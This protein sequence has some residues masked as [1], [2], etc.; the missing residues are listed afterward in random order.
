MEVATG[1]LRIRERLTRHASRMGTLGPVDAR[2]IGR[3]Q[4]FQILRTV[5]QLVAVPVM[6][7]FISTQTPAEKLLRYVTMLA[8]LA[9]VNQHRAV[10]LRVDP[11]HAPIVRQAML[12][13]DGLRT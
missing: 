12:R 2:V 3:G 1:A 9:T 8:D 13:G 5:V 7:R 4:D 11:S 6:D 10:A